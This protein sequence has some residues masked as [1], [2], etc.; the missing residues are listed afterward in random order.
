[1]S[2]RASRAA[3]LAVGDELIAGDQVDLNTSWLA[4]RLGRLGWTVER[5]ALVGDDEEEIA[6]A[7]RDLGER[8]ALVISTGG[9]GPTLDDVT[10]HAAARAAGVE[11]ALD[12]E[13][14]RG[15]HAL[16]E[17]AGRRASA[18]NDRQALFP[19]GAQVLANRAGTAPGFRLR[20]G[21]SD[22]VC[23]PGPPRELHV[24]FEDVVEPW[25]G[26]SPP[27]GEVRRGARF[28][29]IGLSESDF[30]ERV[31]GWMARDANPRM[32]VR[33][34][35]GVLKVKLEAHAADAATCEGLLQRRAAAFR[36]RFAEHIFSEREASPAAA[37]MSILLER[38]CTFAAAESCTGG[39]LSA[40]LTET[41][42]ASEVFRE[43]FVTYSN[44][45]KTARL[46]VPP[47]LLAAHG[48]VSEEVAAAM[49]AGAAERSGARLAVSI[50]GIAG[51]GGGT[52]EKP[53]GTVC[54]GLAHAGEVSAETRR[55]PDR[56]RDL[57]RTWAVH[58]ACD[59]ARRALLGA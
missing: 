46:G 36:E 26:A 16:F 23:L 58:A 14:R 41:P 49:A 56:G 24:V 22:V 28:Y 43:G 30:A 31:G 10:R 4:E 5:A 3:I 25:L 44:E 8:A 33:A 32:G 53:V 6:A 48:A 18:A 9:L 13:V 45:A 2:A 40:E 59:L 39:R 34:G 51:P 11:L 47:A 21:A 52:L 57:V 37:L 42:G 20:V 50:T 38:G 7:L 27:P 54:F 1:M 35:G 12:E 29:L 17:R 19:V 55:F 15:I